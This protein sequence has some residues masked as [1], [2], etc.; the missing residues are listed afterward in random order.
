[1]TRLN[2]K[3]NVPDDVLF[4]ELSGEAVILN[5]STGK[6]YGLDTVGTRMW[7]LL[8]EHRSLEPAFNILLTEYKVDKEQ[9]ETD[10]LELV[11]DLSAHG[12]LQIDTE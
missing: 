5:L 11:N 7:I 9:L 10:L 4:H 6:Y 1:M 2:A 12:L 8:A 3:I